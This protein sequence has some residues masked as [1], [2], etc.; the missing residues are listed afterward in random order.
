MKTTNKAS[1]FFNLFLNF[2]LAV[3]FTL[4][5][6]MDCFRVLYIS[7]SLAHR[8]FQYLIA[9]ACILPSLLSN[10]LNRECRWISKYI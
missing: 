10:L 2:G 1:L 5:L 3:E 7:M 9:V 4:T 8:F 6:Q